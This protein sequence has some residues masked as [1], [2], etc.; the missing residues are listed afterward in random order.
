MLDI[1]LVRDSPDI[2]RQNLGKRNDNA[3]ME[4]LEEL[5]QKDLQWRRSLEKANTL[6]AERNALSKKIAE[7]KKAGGDAAEL[8]ARSAQIPE[9]I[10]AL[11]KETQA[12]KSRVDEILM[13][14]PNLLHD[15]VPVGADD[16][17]NVVVRTWG[18]PR[19]VDFELKSHGDL[20]ESAGLA[21]FDRATRIAGSGFNYLKGDLARLDLAL[22][23]YAVNF[24]VEK[25][26]MVIEPPFM[27]RRSA[28]EGVTDLGDFE[29]VMYK[30]EGEDLYLIATSEHPMAAMFMGEIIDEDLLPLKF[31]GFSPCF[32]R[33][34]GAHG[35]DTRGLFR[36]HQFNKVEQFVFCRP[37]DS[38]AMHEELQANTEAM[39]QNLGL[40]YRVVN[41]CT[42]DIGTLAAKKYDIEVWFP[43]QGRF[44][45]VTS[46]SND[47]DYQARRLNIRCGK[48]GS[49]KKSVPHTLNNTAI[50]TSR[51]MVAILENCQNADGTV[52]VPKVLRPYMGGKQTIG[53]P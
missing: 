27:M 18:K 14:L 37:D 12:L 6:K 30:I 47:T 19:E 51:T 36:M 50:A 26:F 33:E 34:I 46:C 9:D 4:M 49:D 17:N 16:S 40:P 21:D 32:R 20:A 53:A 35:V 29:Q 22:V 8:L 5:I 2:V 31:V 25:E 38:W 41:V 28:Y 52:T 7:T 10:A 42:G 3:K 23:N 39:F 11:D 45:E 24:L 13:R 44:G 48:H 43:R 15:S 1:K